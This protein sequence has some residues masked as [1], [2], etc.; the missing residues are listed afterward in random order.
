[1]RHF[2]LFLLISASSTLFYGQALVDF[3]SDSANIDGVVT[4]N[5]AYHLPTT[6]GTDGQV[7]TT[8]GAGQS[9]WSSLSASTSSPSGKY[10]YLAPYI[11]GKRGDS[12]FPTVRDRNDG[13][14]QSAINIINPFPEEAPLRRG[15]SLTHASVDT[16]IA[17]DVI[18]APAP[19]I[20]LDTLLEYHAFALTCAEIYD[21]L[22]ALVFPLTATYEGHVIIESPHK[23]QVTGT[24]TYKSLEL[25]E[26]IESANQ[27]LGVGLGLGTGVSIDVEL[28][29]PIFVPDSTD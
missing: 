1:M 28:V 3:E 2:F 22:G 29:Q 23:L 6:D 19:D 27:A 25:V 21:M 20:F 24:Y 26:R 7:L 9:N 14:Y 13:Q 11:C 15:T 17:P 4:I 5:R 12:M 10:V 16:L 18:K 8:N